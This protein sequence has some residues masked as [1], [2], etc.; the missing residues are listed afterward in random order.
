MKRKIRRMKLINGED[1]IE[2]KVCLERLAAG[3]HPSTG[4]RRKEDT[5]LNEVDVCRS[6]MIAAYVMDQV[7]KNGGKIDGD[8]SRR[9][10]PF[11]MDEWEKKLIRISPEPIGIA[12][13]S[14]RITDVID[15]DMKRIPGLHMTA[16][17][18]ACGFLKTR[19][20]N[21]ERIKIPTKAG[22]DLGIVMVKKTTRDGRDYY[23]NLYNEEAQNFLIDHLDAIVNYQE[24]RRKAKQYGLDPDD[25]PVS[26]AEPEEKDGLEKEVKKAVSQK[27]NKKE[28]KTEEKKKESSDEKKPSKKKNPK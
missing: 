26:E 11:H 16:W 21:D 14:N 28:K 24:K 8:S 25:I 9:K 22:E 13:F 15:P 23:K 20:L 7:I 27:E 12:A 6:L 19:E 3:R 2:A 18:E 4:E 1:L 5:L 17:L 10:K